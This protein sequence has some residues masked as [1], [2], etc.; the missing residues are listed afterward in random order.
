MSPCLRDNEQSGGVLRAVP[1]LLLLAAPMLVGQAGQVLMQ[2]TDTVMVG[3]LG[4]VPLAG[5]ALAGNFLMF[6][7][8]FAYGSLGAVAPRI[9]HAFG[10]GNESGV[11]AASRAGI[12]LALGIG[13]FVAIVLTFFIPFLGRLG[14]PEEVVGVAGGYLFLLAWS[15]P[16]ALVSLVL[17]QT[18]E[19]VNRPWPVVAFMAGALVLN[20]I[21]N[22]L[23]IFG[24]FGFPALG[25]VGSGWATLAARWAQTI[26]MGIWIWRAGG[27]RRFAVF[28]RRTDRPLVR[29]LL[30]DGLPVAGQDVLEGGSFA[31]G[32]LMM[33]W[34][35]VTAL[36]ANQV[37]ISI[38]SLAWMFPISLS[39]AA[40]VRV[41][42]AMG[43]GD[44]ASARRSGIAGVM[45]GAG[46]MSVCAVIYVVFGKT[47]AGMFTSDHEVAALAGTLV[48][49]AGVYQISDAIQ[50]VSLGSL[51][52]LLDNRVPLVANAVCYWGLC[53]P[54]VY[55]LTF[56]MDLGAVG[57]WLG[58][59]PWMALT[60]VFFLWRFLRK[61]SPL[62]QSH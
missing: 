19:A 10:A 28:R 36:A 51:R 58:Y 4:P 24:H 46:L 44:L 3:R 17:G 60:G 13:I 27:M 43:A 2:I 61:T 5:A 62:R 48:T 20:G 57:M 8:Y 42:Q 37:T 47:F 7:L 33:G 26:A 22:Y 30:H 14:Q 41:A 34:V 52:G 53:L 35:G 56:S 18:A 32:S 21:L 29:S 6:A 9:A 54:T 55:F 25:L 38:A 16:G 59:L 23:L 45:V 50:S 39:M 12:V 31:I 1:P 11:G 15:L 40:G 49:I